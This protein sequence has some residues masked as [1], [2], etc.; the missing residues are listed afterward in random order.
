MNISIIFPNQIFQKS[1]LL[2][3]SSKIVLIEEFLFFKQFK[4]HKQ[5][6]LFHRMTLKI[7]QSYLKEKGYDVKY[8]DSIEKNSDIRCFIK[9]LNNDIKTIKIYDPVDNWLLKRIETICNKKNIKIEIF[10]NPLFLN[11]NQELEGFFRA[12]KKKFFQ[13]YFFQEMILKHLFIYL[14][15]LSF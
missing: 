2:D 5:K 8:I 9:N 7:Y 13:T 12:D 3:K 15:S 1:D 10:N 14:W 4:F 11:N 6:I